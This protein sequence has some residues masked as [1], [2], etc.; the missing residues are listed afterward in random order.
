M[1]IT[2]TFSKSFGLA[3]LRAG[4][5]ITNEKFSSL[6]NKF[7]PMYEINSIAYLA[8]EFLLKNNKIIKK[9]IKDVLHAKSFY[10]RR[11]KKVEDRLFRHKCKF[12]SYKKKNSDVE[13]I[14]KKNK[15]LVFN[16][17]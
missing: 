4:Y 8:I 1:I 7:R 16:L 6:L 15:I 11:I 9:H 17:V 13:N 12:F 14:F 2:R 3:G 5:T 10:D